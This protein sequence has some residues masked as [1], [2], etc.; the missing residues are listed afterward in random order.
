MLINF[1]FACVFF[2]CFNVAPHNNY[3]HHRSP[4]VIIL[5]SCCVLIEPYVYHRSTTN[6]YPYSCL[7]IVSI[8][9]IFLV[10]LQIHRIFLILYL[11]FFKNIYCVNYTLNIWYINTKI[12]SFFLWVPF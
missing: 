10:A 11:C 3:T 12:H 2:S 6:S 8:S 4:S 1:L 7:K 9:L 5:L